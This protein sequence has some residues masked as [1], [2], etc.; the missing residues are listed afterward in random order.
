MHELLGG[1]AHPSQPEPLQRLLQTQ[2]PASAGRGGGRGVH[3]AVHPLR[4]LYRDLPLQL[5]QAG[6]SL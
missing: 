1:P 4:A 5:H 2:P 3:G 6:R